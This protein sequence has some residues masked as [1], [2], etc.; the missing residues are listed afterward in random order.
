MKVVLDNLKKINTSILNFM[1]SGLK[2]C[3]ILSL[4]SA[5]ILSLY[6]SVHNLHLFILGFSLLK[7]S[8]FFTVFFIISAI[9]I[10]TIKKDM[11]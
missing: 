9:A 5:F 10:D 1:Y 8:L 4:F 3:L 11:K 2:F 6:L 7:S